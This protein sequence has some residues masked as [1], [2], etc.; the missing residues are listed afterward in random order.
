MPFSIL[1]PSTNSCII[2]RGS[3]LWDLTFNL[4]HL[5]LGQFL[6]PEIYSWRQMG[7]PAKHAC[8]NQIHPSLLFSLPPSYPTFFYHAF[9]PSPFLVSVLSLSQQLPAL[10]TRPHAHCTFW[11][12]K[13]R[14]SILWPL[15][16]S[17]L[18]FALPFS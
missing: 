9:L 14:H 3:V 16:F 11:L 15:S 12:K 7:Q 4:L 1:G 8:G 10:H 5:S 17:M 6:P 2:C 13:K 18:H